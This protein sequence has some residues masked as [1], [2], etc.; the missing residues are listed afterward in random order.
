MVTKMRKFLNVVLILNFLIV[1]LLNPSEVSH[2]NL[3][4][5]EDFSEGLTDWKI[6]GWNRTDA[7]PFE[8]NVSNAN[9]VLRIKGEGT[10]ETAAERNCTQ[11]VGS[12]IFDL[13][14]VHTIGEHFHL[15]YFSGAFGNISEVSFPAAIPFEY[16]IMV[17]TA[18]VGPFNSE[19][20]FYNRNQGNGLINVIDQYSPVEIIGWH[21][22]NIT[23]TIS[24]EFSVSVN[25][26]LVSSFVDTNFTTTEVFRIYSAPGP[27]LDNVMVCDEDGCE[28]TTTTTATTTTD[29]A[30][31]TSTTIPQTSPTDDIG[32]FMGI[33]IIL[34]LV[35]FRIGRKRRNCR[36]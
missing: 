11:A 1:F 19:F 25:G 33:E 23:R 24:G 6:F 28:T 26:T 35:G 21:H 20:V 4:W 36:Q 2:A 9:E 29:L 10:Q 7:V 16:G 31:S 30:S 15:A 14:V 34:I 27:G 5:N 32:G 13:D 22:F 18:V 3:I 17:V 8:G 12:W